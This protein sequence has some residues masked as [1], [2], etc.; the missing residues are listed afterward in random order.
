MT[1]KN[2]QRWARMNTESSKEIAVTNRILIG[3]DQNSRMVPLAGCGYEPAD[4]PPGQQMPPGYNI[5]SV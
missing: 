3:D 2:A 1:P 5:Q 4:S